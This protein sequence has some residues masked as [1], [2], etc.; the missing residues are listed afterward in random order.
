MYVLVKKLNDY[1]DPP[2]VQHIANIDVV[3]HVSGV[4]LLIVIIYLVV[5]YQLGF[6]YLTI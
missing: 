4:T 3:I 2:H 6:Y 5:I 1:F